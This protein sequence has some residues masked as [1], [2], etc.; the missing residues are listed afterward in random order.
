MLF[1]PF[2]V[3]LT[4][5]GVFIMTNLSSSGGKQ[6]RALQPTMP[7]LESPR[8]GAT[9]TRPS[10]MMTMPS[11]AKPPS[12]RTVNL[13][14]LLDVSSSMEGRKL[15][16]A[17]AAASDCLAEIASQPAVER[18]K[19]GLITFDGQARVLERLARM[20]AGCS[21]V[22]KA[23]PGNGRTN[24]KA[25]VEL[26]MRELE[27]QGQADRAG[28]LRPV[29][30]VILLSDGCANVGDPQ[31]EADRARVAGV[32]VVTIAFGADADQAQLRRLATTPAHAYAAFDG[33]TLRALFSRL[34]ATLSQAAAA[35]GAI[36]H[37]LATI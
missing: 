29:S 26:A 28:G 6:S 31:P 13:L 17:N 14:L 37:A 23:N 12:S 19:S 1:S 4:K 2:V 35:G 8:V 16:A 10:P 15:W 30:V 11:V 20:R 34:G 3:A 22:V 36:Q 18:F 24:I 21:A 7:S 9:M 32:T 27:E 25:A 5:F 33:P